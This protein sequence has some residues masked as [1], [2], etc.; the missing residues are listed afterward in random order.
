MSTANSTAATDRQAKRYDFLDAVR[1]I[2]IVLM[3]IYHLTFGF[4]QLGLLDINFSV[5]M[6]WLGFRA[7]I[8]FL[9]L[10]LVGIGLF[11]ATRN[12][13]NIKSF[14]K[15]QLL[16]F[17]YAGLI[18]AFSWYVRPIHAVEF[19]ILHLIFVSSLIGLFL[20]KSG[21]LNL[22]LGIA[23]VVVGTSVN[24]EISPDSTVAAY[25]KWLGLTDTPNYADDFAPL[26]PWFGLVLIGIYIGNRLFSRESLSELKNWKATS[27][28][29]QVLCWMGRF[30]IHLYFFH[31]QFFYLL[32][33]LFN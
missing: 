28:V 14:T 3:F 5:D 4:A 7:L 21:R 17:T 11:L 24:I 31:F 9:F 1:G 2:A 26:F 6:F 15:R 16:L 12:K 20:V 25:I 18:S 27:I 8:V 19:G 29:A 30:S 32:V 33:L 13:L 10:G 22:I 23:I